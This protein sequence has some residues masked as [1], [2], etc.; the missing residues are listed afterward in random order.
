MK[1]IKSIKN[2]SYVVAKKTLAGGHFVADSIADACIHLEMKL[3][4][5]VDPDEVAMHRV[6]KSFEIRQNIINR[7]KSMVRGG[8]DAVDAVVIKANA[9]IEEIKEFTMMES[10]TVNNLNK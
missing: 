5:D 1:L 7:A 6:T 2:A 10:V 4:K 3:D 9:T 8:Q